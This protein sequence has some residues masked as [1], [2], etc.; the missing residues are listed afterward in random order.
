MPPINLAMVSLRLHALSFDGPCALDHH[1][2]ELL[3]RTIVM[4]EIANLNAILDMVSK[5][6]GYSVI[7]MCGVDTW[8]NRVRQE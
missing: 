2:P 3:D 8:P 1:V 5:G 6:Y 7:P 4:H